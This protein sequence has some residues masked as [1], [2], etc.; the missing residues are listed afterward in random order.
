MTKTQENKM[1]RVYHN[2][3]AICHLV[4]TVAKELN[5]QVVGD[6]THST[7]LP[8][9]TKK[10]S[11]LADIIFLD[12]RFGLSSLKNATTNETAVVALLD[13][14]NNIYAGYC[15]SLG[16][17]G[18]LPIENAT[19]SEV[20]KV[21]KS[22]SRGNVYIPQGA[23]LVYRS[24]K[25]NAFSLEES[26]ASASP[27]EKKALELFLKGYTYREITA[28]MKIARQTLDT[29][30][31][32]LKTK[33]KISSLTD[34]KNYLL[35]LSPEANNF[36]PSVLDNLTEQE[37]KVFMLSSQT[38]SR[39]ETA[40]KLGITLKTLDTYSARNRVKLGNVSYHQYRILQAA[41]NQTFNKIRLVST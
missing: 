36:D 33:L 39:K 14:P 20:T 12:S 28:K 38:A 1:V 9:D 23:R 17:K 2:I 24:Q 3:P 25:G 29:Y 6:S 35:S 32:R 34:M 27:Q 30:Y 26:L 40:L 16:A 21:L 37:R 13:K 19:P 7:T 4:N 18:Y 22:V 31:D 10:L 11:R 41:F 5:F 8:K 15:F